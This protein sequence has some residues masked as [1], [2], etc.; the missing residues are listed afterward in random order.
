L[1]TRRESYQ[2]RQED[3]EVWRRI[4]KAA[5]EVNAEAYNA[6]QVYANG[7][8][9]TAV[10]Q[11]WVVL[12][13]RFEAQPLTFLGSHKTV[14]NEIEVQRQRIMQWLESRRE[15]FDFQLQSY[16]QLL[17]DAGIRAELR[18]PFDKEKPTESQTALVTLVKESLDRHFS[19]LYSNLKNSL[20]IIR[21]SIQVQSLKLS[22]IESRTYEA[23]QLATK[24]REQIRIE[25]ISDQKSF[26]SSI[27]RPL[28]LLAEEE[29]K[30][31]EE[32][33]Q[34]I[35]QRPAAGSE[36]KLMKLF[37]SN[38]FGQEVDLRELIMRLI[39]QR[40]GTVDLSTLMQDV[41]SL[42]QK[43]LVDVH[44]KLSGSER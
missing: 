12:R 18:V 27:L 28:V 30:L 29:K 24:L 4:S 23:L 34:A 42:F 17:A 9:K 20:Q 40:E 19:V 37:Q 16:Q 21:Y 14:S 6:Y 11:L 31:E 5:A 39:D 33:Q 10:D 35:Q 2:D 1:T 38:G 32:V 41:E 26:Q 7:E 44:I 43:N 36:L 22:N 8:F 13:G 15:E 25:T 3:F